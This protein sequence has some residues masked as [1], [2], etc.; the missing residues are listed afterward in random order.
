MQSKTET[1]VQPELGFAWWRFSGWATLI[2]GT[3]YLLATGLGEYKV[4]G[5]LLL[6][7]NIWLGAAILSMSRWA[8]LLGTIA[9][10]NPILWVINGIYLKNRW[11][12]PRVVGVEAAAEIA[13]AKMSAAPPRPTSKVLGPNEEELYAA[14]MAEVQ[15]DQ[16]RPGLWA[17]CFAQSGGSEAAATAQYITKRV[18]ELREDWDRTIR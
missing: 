1:P 9:S 3:L 16:R 13:A 2:L 6:V 7:L 11:N 8:F 10:L 15:G 17:L 5:A 14:A 12:H 18:L 4:V